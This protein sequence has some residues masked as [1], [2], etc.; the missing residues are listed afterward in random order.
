MDN[1]QIQHLRD[2]NK[3]QTSYTINLSMV[4]QKEITISVARCDRIT[5]LSVNL[6]A[7]QSESATFL[8]SVYYRLRT[9]I[10]ILL[11]NLTHM[12]Q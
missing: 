7:Y 8:E 2:F 12:K 10:G 1:I 9:A 4:H 11:I 3:L 5:S 6:S